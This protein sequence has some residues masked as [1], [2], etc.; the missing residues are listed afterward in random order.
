MEEWERVAR[1]LTRAAGNYDVGVAVHAANGKFMWSTQVL[2]VNA[3][4]AAEAAMTAG[5][6][7]AGQVPEG[8]SLRLQF[9]TLVTATGRRRVDLRDQLLTSLSGPEWTEE[10]SAARNSQP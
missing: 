2:D 5:T 8:C 9:V 7:Y 3:S 4:C 10:D 6:R 1:E